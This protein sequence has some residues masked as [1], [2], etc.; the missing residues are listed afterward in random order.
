MIMPPVDLTIHAGW[1]GRFAE[2]PATVATLAF[3][4]LDVD[5]GIPV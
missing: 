1:W 5:I 3:T 4:D 2:R